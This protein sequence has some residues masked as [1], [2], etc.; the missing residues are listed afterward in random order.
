MTITNFRAI[1]LVKMEDLGDLVLIAGQNGVGKS[2]IFD[3]IR[4]LKSSYGGYSDNEI[5]SWYN[6]FL[7]RNGNEYNIDKILRDKD[8]PI[9]I[10]ATLLLS[11][12]E[13]IYLKKNGKR[14]IEKL[15]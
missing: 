5:Q 10:S 12:G 9:T 8:L 1:E 7:L 11:D 14:I 6:E 13:I 2:C 4:L 15:F 3:C